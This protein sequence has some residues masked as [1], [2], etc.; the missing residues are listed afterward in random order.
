VSVVVV[1]CGKVPLSFSLPSF[2]I[3]ALLSSARSLSFARLSSRTVMVLSIVA[4]AFAALLVA[5]AW[6]LLSRR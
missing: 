4:G 2:D 5:A 1:D 6:A 3:S